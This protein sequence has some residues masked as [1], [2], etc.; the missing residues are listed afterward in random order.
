[1]KKLIAILLLVILTVGILG[2]TKNTQ[3][4]QLTLKHG[5]SIHETVL[6]KYINGEGLSEIV[7][8]HNEHKEMIVSQGDNISVDGE[9]DVVYM[10]I[11]DRTTQEEIKQITSYVNIITIDMEPG[12]YTYNFKVDWGDEQGEY[13]KNIT[14]E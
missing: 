7:D 1:M 11:Y 3:T 10:V 6:M 4:K 13:V 12:E 2:C 14:V 9:L 5:E 8:N